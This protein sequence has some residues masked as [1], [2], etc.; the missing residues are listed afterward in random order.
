FERASGCARSW[1]PGWNRDRKRSPWSKAVWSPGRKQS[2]AANEVMNEEERP[3]GDCGRA[4][5][6]L[7]LRADGAATPSQ[8]AEID[9]HLAGCEACRRAAAVDVA[10]RRRVADRMDAPAPAWL[11]GFA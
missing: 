11:A 1:P 5:L 9:A 6:L 2:G 7:S 10:V 3:I 8:V 4:R